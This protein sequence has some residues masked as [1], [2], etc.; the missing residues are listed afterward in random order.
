MLKGS[1]STFQQPPP[2]GLGVVTVIFL[3][4]TVLQTL[5]TPPCMSHVYG[6]NLDC[7]SGDSLYNS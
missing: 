7:L 4:F 6:Y 5:S 1:S 2:V 3:D